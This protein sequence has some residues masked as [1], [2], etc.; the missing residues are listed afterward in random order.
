M[1]VVA[2]VAATAPSSPMPS[3]MVSMAMTRPSSLSG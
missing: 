2:V 3:T 1:N